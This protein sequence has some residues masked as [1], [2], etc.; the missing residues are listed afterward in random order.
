M[1]I[2]VAKSCLCG[3]HLKMEY[4]L[5]GRTWQQEMSPHADALKLL[6]KYGL[7]VEVSEQA[8]EVT[9]GRCILHVAN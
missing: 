9:S 7:Q 1:K 8:K 2:G 3:I 6:G 5:D 4:L